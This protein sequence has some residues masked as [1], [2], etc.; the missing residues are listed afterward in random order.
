MATVLSLVKRA[1]RLL[2]DPGR[3][4]GEGWMAD[5]TDCRWGNAELLEWLTDAEREYFLAFPY[6]EEQTHAFR[7][8]AHKEMDANLLYVD[9]VTRSD[10][11]ALVKR[12]RAE[13]DLTCR[14]WQDQTATQPDSWWLEGQEGALQLWVYPKPTG[15]VTLT[16][17]ARRLPESPLTQAQWESQEPECPDPEILAV[18][19][20]AQGRLIADQDKGAPKIADIY[21]AQFNALVPPRPTASDRARLREIAGSQC[22]SRIHY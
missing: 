20:A 16:V 5:D 13:M 9:G 3:A 4:A 6:R 19:A 8:V 7:A 1:R 21:L 22:V 11:V 14:Y 12:S 2:D 10:G 18:Y 17:Q 15:T